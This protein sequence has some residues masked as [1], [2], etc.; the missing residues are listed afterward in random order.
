ML[1]P[2]K[3]NYEVFGPLSIP[4]KAP[5]GSPSA[6][7]PVDVEHGLVPVAEGVRL[8]YTVAGEG[9]PVL[10][11][12]G[13]PQ[14]WYS[15][16]FMIP[17]FVTAGRKVYAVDTRGLGDSDA[18]PEGFD[19]ETLARDL[20]VLIARLGLDQGSGVD[21]VSHDTGSW[22]AHAL[23]VAYP[24][25]VRR[26]VL[27]DAFIPGVSPN[28]PAGYPDMVMVHRQWHFYFNRVE[29]L[30]EAM[31]E[32]KE[33]TWLSWFFGPAK[34]A[35]TWTIEPTAFEEYLRVF[36]K[37][38]AVRAGLAYYRHVF[39]PEGR[40]ASAL[41][42]GCMIDAPTLALG[43]ELADADNLYQ[44]MKSVAPRLAGHVFPGIGHHLPEECPEQMFERV[45][46]FWNENLQ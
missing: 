46:S 28:P 35:R 45:V 2:S 4:Y 32:G 44:T 1:S 17:M 25:D 29:G 27:S 26:L 21:I 15:W 38:G 12:H 13:W 31:I 36:S 9:E 23:A 7:I 34:L 10:L 41:R 22:I 20:H 19:L 40:S 14:S 30:P 43:G 39:S 5:A 16:R 33:R 42:S 3:P 6:T 24:E 11:I 8:H 18:P 37:P